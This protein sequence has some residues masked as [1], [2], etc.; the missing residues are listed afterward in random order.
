MKAASSSTASDVIEFPAKTSPI[1]VFF[2]V[3]P[4]L[5]LI[6]VVVALTRNKFPAYLVGQ[7]LV[8][9][10]GCIVLVKLG[11]EGLGSVTLEITPQELVVKRLLGSTSYPWSKIES[12]KAFNPGPTFANSGRGEDGH[13]GLGLF[14]RMPDKKTRADDAE[15]D[16]LL[17]S[18]TSDDT[19]KVKKACNRLELARRKAM[20]SAG[21]EQRRGG[22][23]KPAKGFR[24]PA[25]A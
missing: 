3:V 13:A 14:L 10:G 17:V 5:T 15:P 24:R 4:L 7:L 18:V 21:T 22:L 8:V 2:V 1:A 23:G 6:A 16:V 19:D 20:G 12:A 9:A 11:L 25:A